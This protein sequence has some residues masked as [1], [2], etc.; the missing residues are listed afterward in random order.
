M[1]DTTTPSARRKVAGRRSTQPAI[2]FDPDPDLVLRWRLTCLQC[3]ATT[4]VEKKHQAKA[5]L[6]K[7]YA[8]KHQAEQQALL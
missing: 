6:S 3:G 2:E 7:H 5:R 8:E 1:T 4:K